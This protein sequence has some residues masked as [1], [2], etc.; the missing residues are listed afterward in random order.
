MAAEQQAELWGERHMDAPCQMGSPG[1]TRWGHLPG[2][3]HQRRPRSTTACPQ[4]QPMHASRR[5]HPPPP[6]PQVDHRCRHSRQQRPFHT[7]RLPRCR[8]HPHTLPDAAATTS[9]APACPGLAPATQLHPS[10][11]TLPDV[12]GKTSAAPKLT[13]V[14]SPDGSCASAAATASD[15]PLTLKAVVY[16]AASSLMP[17]A[18]VVCDSCA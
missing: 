10:A 8:A 12:A 16:E 17:A 5:Q 13:A 9:A 15:A 4:H 2:G 18:G 7:Q 14:A 3:R 1:L 11:H 6:L